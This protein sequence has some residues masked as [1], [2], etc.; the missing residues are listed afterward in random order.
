MKKFIAGVAG[1]T[2]A[3]LALSACSA[4]GTAATSAAAGASSA[5]GGSIKVSLIAKGTSYRRMSSM[6]RGVPTPYP[7]R[8]AAS[9]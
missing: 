8:S 7:M 9:P 6:I 5:A 1:A 4:G 3:V 2:I